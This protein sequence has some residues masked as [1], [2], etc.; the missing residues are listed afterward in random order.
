MVRS[1]TFMLSGMLRR[2]MRTEGCNSLARSRIS[3][4][5]STR[6]KSCGGARLIYRSA[7]AESYRQLGIRP[8][9]PQAHLLV[10]RNPAT[11]RGLSIGSATAE[12]HGQLG[13]DPG[14]GRN[15][16]LVRGS[17]PAAGFR[18]RRTTAAI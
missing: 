17:V 2:K 7:A 1:S 10:R 4:S 9:D 8:G 14:D 3:P 15:H 18:S 11:E 6:K 12:S 5:G 13:I 16:L